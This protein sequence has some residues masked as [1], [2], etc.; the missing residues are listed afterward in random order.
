MARWPT[1]GKLRAEI[2]VVEHQGYVEPAEAA[3]QAVSIN[4]ALR[5]HV[6]LTLAPAVAH[7]AWDAPGDVRNTP[8]SRD[9]E[10]IDI[11]T[12]YR[13]SIS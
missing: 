9:Y 5:I 13:D 4:P 6:N 7:T 1:F 10:D 12:R 2:G 11:E 8:T 3:M